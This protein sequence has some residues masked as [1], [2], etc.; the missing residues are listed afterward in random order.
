MLKLTTRA[1]IHGASQRTLLKV[2]SLDEFAER[3]WPPERSALLIED[4]SDVERFR[5]VM[6]LSWG[7]VILKNGSSPAFC[8]DGIRISN[9]SEPEAIDVGDVIGISQERPIVDILYRRGANANT[10]FVTAQCNS[11]CLMCSQP[12][13][14]EDD[15]W[16][17]QELEELIP[18]IDQEEE[19]L[20]L[21]GG[22]PTLLREDL[23]RLIKTCQEY[24]PTTGLHILTNGRLFQDFNFASKA[25]VLS[26]PKITWAIPLY[27]DV[28]WLHDHIVQA[29]GAFDETMAG[30]YNLERNRQN[31]EIRIVLTKP[32]IERL[33]ELSRYIFWNISFASHVTFM[34]LEP[35][36]Y[37]RP[38]YEQVWAD[39][40]D[41]SDTLEKS[42]YYLSNR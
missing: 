4:I 17:I 21:S 23:F 26:D 16:R 8:E 24:L 42:V 15:R 2:V 33:E 34:G 19:W 5:G 14:N 11:L 3:G 39:P 25:G 32:T 9:I 13:Q 22:E 7:G 28:P 41:Y 27:G 36:G 38:N 6:E 10:L 30:I 12:P 37:A 29:E 20:G 18:L 1:E 40:V 35:I 31:I